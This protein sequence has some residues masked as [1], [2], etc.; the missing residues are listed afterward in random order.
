MKKQSRK[1]KTAS[2]HISSLWNEKTKYFFVFVLL[3]LIPLQA[4]TSIRWKSATVEEGVHLAAGAYYLKT[5]D[6]EKIPGYPPLIRMWISLPAWLSGVKIPDEKLSP[7]DMYPFEFGARFLYEYNDADSVL[8]K[9]RSMV[10]LLSLL[11]G[12]YVFRLTK[13]LFGWE[14]AL[15]SLLFYCFCPNI[16]ANSRITTLDLPL[17]AFFFITLFYYR[18]ALRN[19]GKTGIILSG[20]FAFLTLSAKYSGILLF[21]VLCILNMALFFINRKQPGSIRPS[22]RSWKIF[23]FV[24][25]FSVFMINL[26]YGFKGSF[27]N[28]KTYYESLPKNQHNIIETIIPESVSKVPVLFS[29][30]LPVPREYLRGLDLT[31]Y[32]DLKVIH[33]NWYLG[34]LYMNGEHWWH[35]YLTAMGLKLPPASLIMILSA[36][37]AGTYIFLKH[38]DKKEEVSILFTPCLIFFLFFSFICHSQLGLR[39]ILPVFPFLFTACGFSTQ[40]LLSKKRA[41]YFILP[42]LMGW[43]LFSSISIYPHYLS[44]FNEIAGGPVKGIEYFADSNLDWGQDIKGLKKY[45]NEKGIK[46]INLIYY[47][48]NGIPETNYYGIKTAQKDRI[49]DSPWAVSATWL[50]YADTEPFK[51]DIPFSLKSRIP[52]DRIGYSI[53]VYLPK[54]H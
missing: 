22:L 54:N 39:L 8:F 11:L 35:Y 53:N 10:V 27:G 21:P 4:L 14:A 1:A 25:F 31:I 6:F 30:P 33:P 47:G 40:Y 29:F 15:I 20:V 5:G 34:K 46:E 17:T 43:Y 41:G 18:R 45:M 44:Y 42:V 49:S 3:A 13:D 9:G 52:D 51:S 36:L 24:L 7:D 16:L 50:Y 48:P 28:I 23:V 2:R 37:F 12:F 38:P 26:E 19:D 32:Y